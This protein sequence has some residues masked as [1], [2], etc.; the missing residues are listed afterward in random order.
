MSETNAGSE[1]SS[2]ETAPA[3]A[4]GS[5]GW[6]D[7]TVPNADEVR[8]FYAEVTGW[9]ATPLSMGEYSDYV[10]QSPGAPDAAAGICHARGANAGL[11]PV[12]LVYIVVA[13]LDASLAACHARGGSVISGPRG[14]GG[15]ARF[16]IIRD[17][18]G[19]VAALYQS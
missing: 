6:L 13:D 12:W 14:A 3:K 7:L 4:V 1:V 15:T 18:A 9:E 8:D 17:P 2:P 5:I 10:M 19:A 16:A 11:P